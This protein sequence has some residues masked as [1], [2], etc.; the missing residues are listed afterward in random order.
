MADIIP[1][2][3]EPAPNLE[4]LSFADADTISCAR[5]FD[6]FGGKTP[7]LSNLTLNGVSVRWDSEILHDLTILDLSWIRFPST[8]AILRAL[9]HSPHL[10]NLIIYR[11]STVS[12][13]Q[14]PFPSIQLQKLLRL[15]VD[16]DDE[17]TT[18]NFLDRIAS[19]AVIVLT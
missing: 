18:Q 1:A 19:S 11:C 12:R 17:A 8:D 9:S 4:N 13:A 3:T 5:E 14:P 16:L 6:L 7:R 15:E 2:L 10:E